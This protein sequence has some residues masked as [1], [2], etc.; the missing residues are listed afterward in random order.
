MGLTG[1]SGAALAC[2]ATL[3]SV[4]EGVAVWVGS[5]GSETGGTALESEDCGAVAGSAAAGVLPDA[6]GG[7]S[8]DGAVGCGTPIAVG[9]KS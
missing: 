2:A 1:G 3:E 4:A 8:A 5:G 6:A 9:P 7:S